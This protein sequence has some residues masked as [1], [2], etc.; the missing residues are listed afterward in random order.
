VGEQNTK[1]A[2]CAR[3]SASAGMRASLC[4]RVGPGACARGKVRAC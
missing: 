3:A 1:S 4:A 2:P